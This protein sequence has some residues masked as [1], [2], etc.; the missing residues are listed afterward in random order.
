M[1]STFKSEHNWVDLCIRLKN[2][3]PYIRIERTGGADFNPNFVDASIVDFLYATQ[4]LLS[5]SNR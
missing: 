3:E 1:N 5:K 4:A 2:Q